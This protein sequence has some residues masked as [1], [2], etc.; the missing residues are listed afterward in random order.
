MKV[1]QQIEDH[2]LVGSATGVRHF[3][4]LEGPTG[5][6]SWSDEVKARIVAESFQK[7]VRVCDVA[8]RHGLAP[9]HLSTWRRLARDG[10]LALNAEDEQS[11]AM[12]VLESEAGSDEETS[13]PAAIVDAKALT[14]IEIEAAGVIIRLSGD[15]EPER[16]ARIAAA[17]REAS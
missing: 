9:Q 15:T 14:Q 8:R 4:V 17:L 11:F 13:S 5:R 2:L 7:G 16:I 10:K 3:E 12:L 1:L 6:R